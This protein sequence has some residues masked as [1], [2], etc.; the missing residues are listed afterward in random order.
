MQRARK[1]AVFN[2]EYQVKTLRPEDLIGLK[3]QAISND[4]GNRYP[5]DA[6]D[7]HK[8]LALHR[9]KMDMELVREYFRI[10]DKENL[11]DEWLD[12]IK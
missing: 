8:L 12:N 4:P 7:I 3:I 11:L 6:P 2:G 10:F 9:D 5:V 1:R